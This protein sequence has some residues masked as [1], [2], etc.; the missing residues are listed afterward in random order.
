MRVY[1]HI[2]GGLIGKRLTVYVVIGKRLI[3]C[4]MGGGKRLIIVRLIVRLI[5]CK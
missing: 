5:W 2:K 4:N 1:H 3:W